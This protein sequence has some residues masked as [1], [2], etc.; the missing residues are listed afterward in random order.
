MPVRE[1]QKQGALVE[2]FFYNPNVHPLKEFLLRREGALKAAAFFGVPLHFAEN[3]PAYDLFSWLEMTRAAVSSGENG[4]RCPLCWE[5]RLV[6]TACFAARK[7]YEAFS[8]SL[9]YSRRQRHEEIAA[10]G[11]KVGEEYG[12]GFLYQDFRPF[13]QE[14]INL[15]KELAVYRQQ[16]CGCVY[17][18]AERYANELEK[19]Q[20]SA[21][22][23]DG[24]L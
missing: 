1:L 17:S 14:G 19:A 23:G 12:V 22:S 8:T 5:Q 20:K 24:A 9:L 4:A 10:L 16:Y 2:G 7:G 21:R 11:R 15:S 13:W 6:E 18:E 3:R